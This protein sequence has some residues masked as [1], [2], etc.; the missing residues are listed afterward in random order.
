METEVGV[1]VVMVRAEV[2][3]VELGGKEVCVEV[4]EE[5]EWRWWRWRLSG[6]RWRWS[7]W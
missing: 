5:V 7:M 4:V 6:W 2:V 1:G 3:E